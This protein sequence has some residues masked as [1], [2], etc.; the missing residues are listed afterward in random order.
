MKKGI[1]L[2]KSLL[3]DSTKKKKTHKTKQKETKNAFTSGC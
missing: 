2:K 1:L 3:F